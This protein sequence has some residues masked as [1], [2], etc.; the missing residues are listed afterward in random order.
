MIIVTGAAGFI[1]CNLV[2]GLNEKGF[3]NILAVDNI[4]DNKLSNLTSIKIA[5]FISPDKFLELL[6]NNYFANKK[7]DAIFHQGACSDTTCTDGE[8]IMANN[9][10]YSKELFD[11]CAYNNIPFIYA[12]SASVYG[13]GNIFIEDIKYEKPINL[14]AY[15]KYL[16]DQYVRQNIT[17]SSNQVAGL[18]Y[19]NVYG[20]HEEHKGRM[21]SVVLHFHNQ[22]LKNNCVK[23]FKGTDNYANGEQRRDFIHVD[24][25]VNIN[26]WLLENPNI[27]GI[28]NA[29]TGKA[30]SFNQVAQAVIN[31]HG[32]GE[33]EYIDFPQDLQGKY[34]SFTEAN[35]TKLLEQFEYKFCDINVGVNK[36]LNKIY[37]KK[38]SHENNNIK[39]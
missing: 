37:S 33:I 28:F 22:L 8:F 16:F 15:S 26:L 1:G 12:S 39:A 27:S 10:Q 20:P 19:F 23:L 32:F 29:G 21:A 34:Q 24:D 18:R 31:Y 5:D 13:A 14:Y 7:I 3:D 25:I 17:N 35:M 11:F 9:Y 4:T 6:K 36:Y 38:F 30:A 2:K